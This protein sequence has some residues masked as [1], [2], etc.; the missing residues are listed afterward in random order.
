MIEDSYCTQVQDL[1]IS[2]ICQDESVYQNEK[3]RLIE[4]VLL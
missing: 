4:L 3:V 2:V 1:P